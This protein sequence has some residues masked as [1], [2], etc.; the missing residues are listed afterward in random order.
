MS[1]IKVID[2]FTDYRGHEAVRV[3][4]QE[5][6]DYPMARQIEIGPDWV[7]APS[8]EEIHD[9]WERRYGIA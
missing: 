6:D 8:F 5:H 4:T 1:K 2:N 9:R 7:Q 3:I